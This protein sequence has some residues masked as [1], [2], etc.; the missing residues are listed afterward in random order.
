MRLFPEYY[1]VDAMSDAEYIERICNYYD[2]T[3][4]DYRILW[5]NANRLSCGFG[6][7]DED[8]RGH[9]HSL[10]RMNEILAQHAH[11]TPGIRVLDAGCGVGFSAIWMAEK[12][13]TPVVG[14]TLVRNQVERARAMVRHRRLESLVRIE[15]QDYRCTSFPDESFDVVW[16]KE[17]MDYAPDK[18]DFLREAFRLLRPGGRL[19]VEDGFRF[20]RPYRRDD[21]ALMHSWLSGWAILDL[22]TRDELVQWTIDAGFQS[23]ELENI[24]PHMFPSHRRLYHI[25][26]LFY[27]GEW[28][29]HK[30]RVRSDIQHGNIRAA[31][32]QYH[33]LLRNLW[34]EGILSAQKPFE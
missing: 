21:E 18:R 4:L 14:I 23:V 20:G 3:F 11:L 2:E 27:P 25:A 6:Y 13:R 10:I 5:M 15:Q 31:R 22:T 33:A 7:W 24:Q 26:N 30:L 1:A 34:F 16:A 9:A 29:L 32:D 17:S 8:V 12:Y 28:L 19:V